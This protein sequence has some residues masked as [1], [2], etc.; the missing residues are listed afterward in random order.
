MPLTRVTI[1]VPSVAQVKCDFDYLRIYRAE[2]EHGTYTEITTDGTMVSLCS[3][4][5][6]YDFDDE[7]GSE[8]YWYKWRYF[9]SN[10]DYSRYYGPIQGYTPYLTYCTFEDV[11]RNLRS[12]GPS[13]G[14]ISFSDRYKNLR[15][16]KNNT[17]D[18]R[19]KELSISQDYSGEERFVLTFTSAT[20][21]QLEVGEERDLTKRV[22]G[23]GDVTTDFVSDDEVIRINSADWTGT[24][25]VDD[26]I[27]FQTAS[28]MSIN[29]AIRFIQDS[30]ILC[31]VIIE[32][33]IAFT[34]EKRTELRFERGNVP[35]AVRVAAA[36]FAAFFIWTTVYKEQNNP[37]GLPD[38]GKGTE[39]I[40]MAGWFRQG[41]RYL[42]G[43]IKKYTEHFDPE[44]GST[45][46]T[47]PRWSAM[48][49]LFDAVGV[50]YVGEGLKLPQLDAFTERAQMSYEGLLDD[51]LMVPGSFDTWRGMPD[52]SS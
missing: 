28:H 4:Q 35:K 2:T 45:V 46:T 51:D 21:F 34:E 15:Q 17:G 47:A 52:L 30:E 36:K 26:T 7:N 23:T 5:D 43:F 33:N 31:D 12:R 40:N 24:A 13:S 38:V 1:H 3:E 39:E 11:K 18:V 22:I 49:P 44:D 9:S 8:Y 16:G 20:D 6:F 41:M 32:E 50:T 37:G 10:G 14:K 19:L 25:A 29:D 27:E 42:D 48:D